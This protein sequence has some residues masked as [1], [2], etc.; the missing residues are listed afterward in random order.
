MV[1]LNPG[2]VKIRIGVADFVLVGWMIFQSNQRV[3]NFFA[4]VAVNVLVHSFKKVYWEMGVDTPILAC[5]FG[6]HTPCQVFF[7]STLLAPSYLHIPEH[8]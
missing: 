3:F 8:T 6:F 2:N 4:I 5:H 7:M 1:I